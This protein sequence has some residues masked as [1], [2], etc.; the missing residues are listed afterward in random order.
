VAHG[1][2]RAGGSLPSSRPPERHFWLRRPHGSG[3]FS[4]LVAR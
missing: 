1:M 2:V 3:L 4:R